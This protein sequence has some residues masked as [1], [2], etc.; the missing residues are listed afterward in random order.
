MSEQYKLFRRN[1]P[2][3]SKEAAFSLSH[4]TLKAS[5]QRVL[6]TLKVLRLA[7]D[8]RL[9]RAL[10]EEY[11]PSRVRTARAELERAGLIEWTGK[12]MVGP[13][14]RKTRIWR[15]RGE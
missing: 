12:T 9:E 10:V 11:S 1:D 4:R 6:D 8:Y 2:F 14:G 7:A 5:E 15:V 3:T 13:R